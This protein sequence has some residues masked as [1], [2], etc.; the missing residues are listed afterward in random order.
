MKKPKIIQEKTQFSRKNP[1]IY[2]ME[3]TF[4]SSQKVFLKNNNVDSTERKI[5]VIHITFA[6]KVVNYNTYQTCDIIK[7][8]WKRKKLCNIKILIEPQRG[9]LVV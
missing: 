2:D 7:F 5:V 9:K 4:L 3:R 6:A 8:S 1:I